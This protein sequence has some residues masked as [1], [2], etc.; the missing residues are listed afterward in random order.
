M[1]PLT[2]ARRSPSALKMFEI[3]PCYLPNNDTNEAAERGS[4]CHEA[5]ETGDDSKL[6]DIE[7]AWVT[8][9]RNYIEPYLNDAVQVWQEIRLEISHDGEVL[10]YGTC[11]LLILAPEG[12]L[13]LIDYK[14]GAWPV[15]E[16]DRNRQMQAYAVGAFQAHPEVTEIETHI[17]QPPRDEVTTHVYKS[18]EAQHLSDTIA[19]IIADAKH[20]EEKGIFVPAFDTCGFCGR[21]GECP[22]AQMRFR[23]TMEQWSDKRWE[24]LPRTVKPS[25]IK[26][27]DAGDMMKMGSLAKSW[28]YAVT[29]LIGDMELMGEI[30]MPEGYFRITQT[31]IEWAEDAVDLLSKNLS[32]SEWSASIPPDKFL[33]TLAPQRKKL[34]DLVREAAPKGMKGTNEQAFIE[35]L[36]EEEILRDGDTKTYLKQKAERKNKDE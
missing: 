19:G 36:K 26:A 15:D 31:S 3:S 11:D 17:V 10:T 16:A 33:S 18:S 28:G 27:G 14:F 32:D 1:P 34:V 8:K 6:T 12:R 20:A 25:R 7:L 29:R 30:D 4:I 5:I 21:L 22:V 35:F 13:H 24:N 9:A 2:H 23:S